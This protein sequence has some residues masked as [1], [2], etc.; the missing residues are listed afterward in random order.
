[1]P[2]R[3]RPALASLPAHRLLPS[4]IPRRYGRIWNG[5]LRYQRCEFAERHLKIARRS[6]VVVLV[7][8]PAI[9]QSDPS[10]SDFC[11]TRDV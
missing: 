4:L 11:E 2:Q 3:A 8:V 9:G 10:L 7:D 6:E 1:M 5:P